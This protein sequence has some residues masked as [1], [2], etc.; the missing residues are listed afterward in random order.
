[1]WVVQSEPFAIFLQHEGIGS[2]LL[3]LV[4]VFGLLRL[5]LLYS[6]Y[7]V[8]RGGKAAGTWR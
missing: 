2:L 5:G 6:A 4:L 7:R 3:K 8:F 1:M